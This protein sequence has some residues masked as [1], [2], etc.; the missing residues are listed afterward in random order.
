MELITDEE[1]YPALYETEEIKT[2]EKILQLRFYEVSSGWEWYL[3][4][5]DPIDK[6]AFGYVKG[7]ENE[8][9]YFSITEMQDIPTIKRDYEFEPTKFKALYKKMRENR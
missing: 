4:E 9:G 8:W 1:S 3:T 2:D 7:F 6:I 5:Y